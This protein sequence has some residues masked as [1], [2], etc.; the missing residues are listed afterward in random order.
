MA[1]GH[2][3]TIDFHSFRHFTVMDRIPNHDNFFRVILHFI[4]PGHTKRRFSCGI[5]VVYSQ[6]FNKIVGQTMIFDPFNQEFLFTS[7]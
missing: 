4:D 6:Y 7:G 1:I 2:Q 5:L 3:N